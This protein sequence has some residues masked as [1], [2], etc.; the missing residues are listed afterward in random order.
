VAWNSCLSHTCTT[1]VGQTNKGMERDIRHGK[2]RYGHEDA[3]DSSSA[4][5]IRHLHLRFAI[6]MTPDTWRVKRCIII[7]IKFVIS[8]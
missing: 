4:P 7:I 1:P 3:C 8:A 5:A 2:I 6:L